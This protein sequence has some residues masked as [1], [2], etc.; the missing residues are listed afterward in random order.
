MKVL[1]EKLPCPD[2]ELT[3]SLSSLGPEARAN[4]VNE[5][6]ERTLPRLMTFEFSRDRKMMSVLVRRNGA[7]ALLVKG[8]P[9]S[10]LER[11]TAFVVNGH[12]IALTHE[13]RSSLEH[14]GPSQRCL[15]VSVP[16]VRSRA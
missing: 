8:A 1:A 13:L 11:C 14:M 16:D 4:A 12:S 9:E 3:K 5:Y 10:V 7:G 6:Y 2:P 15:V